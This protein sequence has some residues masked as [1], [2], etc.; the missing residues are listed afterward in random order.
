MGGGGL[1]RTP[2]AN[3]VQVPSAGKGGQAAGARSYS[4]VRTTSALLGGFSLKG[5]P[6]S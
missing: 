5:L 2:A 6:R 4:R 3:R 1:S